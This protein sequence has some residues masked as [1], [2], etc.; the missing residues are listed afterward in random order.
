MQYSP[1]N[2]DE[3]KEKF[4]KSFASSPFV[5]VQLDADPDTAV[6]MTAQLDK[7]ADATIWFFTSRDAALAKQGPATAIFAGKDHDIF[8][9]FE[10]VLSEETD[11]ARLEKQWNN[12]VEAWFPG[13]KEDPNLIM[14]RMDLGR[15]EIW[16]GDQSLL[17][18]AKMALGL[19]VRDDM[20]GYNA[21]TVL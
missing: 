1:G 4:W 18:T 10:G 15:A 19:D 5:F 20:K 6:P 17:T 12:F 21:Q 7:D 3:L 11:R 16:R 9:R 8:S 14:L 2:A 13:G